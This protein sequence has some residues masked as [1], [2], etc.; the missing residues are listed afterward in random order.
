MKPPMWAP[1]R[2]EYILGPKDRSGGCIFCAYGEGA[3]ETFRENLVLYADDLA[4]VM[5]NRYPFSAAHLMVIP[6]VH[7]SEP[8]SL[9]REQHDR[10]FQLVT[11]T[12]ERLREAVKPHG[13]NVGLN[14]GEAA[15]AG[16]AEH[17]HVH[18]VPRWQGDTNFMPVIADVRVMPQAL[19]ATWRHLVPFFADL[20][21]AH[22]APLP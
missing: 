15:G 22:P 10:L 3:P 17:L 11:Q 18:L 8:A 2:M 5:L 20:A 19:D 16:I 13:L 7:V 9:T 4:F 21:G 12:G 6:R 14:L 1:W